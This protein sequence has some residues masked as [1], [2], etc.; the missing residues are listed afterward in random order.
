METG[1]SEQYGPAQHEQDRALHERLLQRDPTAPS[2]LVLWYLEPL[3]LRLQHTFPRVDDD[4]LEGVADKVL[5]DVAERPERYDPDRGRLA[6]YLW[7]AVRGD[8][9]NALESERRRA[10][11]HAPFEDV[12]LRPG[13]RNIPW[14]STRDPADVL[15]EA[16]G[17]QRVARLREQF[18]GR[19][20]EV[21]DLISAGER[22]TE[23][24]ARV[25]N[26]QDQ[27]VE[28]QIREVKRVKDRIK[29]K[30]KRLWGRMA[31]DG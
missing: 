6:T 24:Y 21:V 31:D 12:E 17:D 18:L 1:D 10:T 27:S 16:L 22:R 11:H 4:L 8:V 29:K 15:V 2:D 5:F 28:E 13:A 20:R 23:V 14:A 7:I 30:M 9:L 19:E 26:L 25:L 3:T